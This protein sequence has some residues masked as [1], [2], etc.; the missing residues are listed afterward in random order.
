MDPTIKGMEY[1]DYARELGRQRKLL[2]RK[3]STD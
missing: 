1:L 3:D 2:K